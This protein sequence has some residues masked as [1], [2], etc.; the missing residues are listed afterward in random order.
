MTEETIDRS[1]LKDLLEL[2]GGA[3][4]DLDELLDDF[5][6]TSPELV[7][8]IHDA[9]ASGD[10]DAL[11]IAAHTLKSNARDFGAMR[12]SS[13]CEALEYEC[14][15][16]SVRD[17]VAAAGMIEAEE[18]AARQALASLSARNLDG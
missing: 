10:V 7:G 14:R 9:A 2:V 11:R 6:S 4:E 17:A 12:L 3:H 18:A 15:D 5:R 1:A 13:L 16:G 8:Q